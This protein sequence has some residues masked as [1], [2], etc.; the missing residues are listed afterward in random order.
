MVLW[1][2][3]DFPMYGIIGS[4]A[5]SRYVACHPCGPELIDVHSTKLGKC[6]Y[7]KAQR[8]LPKGHPYRM[9]AMKAHFDGQFEFRN[10]P[11]IV[12]VKK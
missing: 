8:W 12:K 3:D 6:T 9:K 10:K 11:M 4:F 5:H 2:I 7:L 1:T